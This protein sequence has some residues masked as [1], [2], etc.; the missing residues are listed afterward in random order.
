LRRPSAFSV[1]NN[2][3]PAVALI[4]SGVLFQYRSGTKFLAL[5]NN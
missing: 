1:G 4:A 2:L 5:A 3:K